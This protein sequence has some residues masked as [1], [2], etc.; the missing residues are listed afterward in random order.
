M[1]R[2]TLL[3]Q[4]WHVVVDSSRRAKIPARKVLTGLERAVVVA[5]G[6]VD[7]RFR[8]EAW[9]GPRD[10]VI[11]ADGGLTL[12]RLLGLRVDV[13]VGDLDSAPPELLSELDPEVELITFPREKDQTDTELALDLAAGRGA[14]EII[15]VGGAGGRLD[16]TWS[17]VTLLPRFVEQG[18]RVTLVDGQNVA[19]AT[20]SRALLQ[21]TPG[22]LVSL[23]PLSPEVS[24]ITTTGLKYG[25]Q[26]GRLAWGSSLGV[27]NEL[28]GERAEIS[29]EAGWLLVVLTSD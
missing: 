17:N 24:G 14:R 15:V 7:A 27:S 22:Q 9:V 4:E 25:L 16:H 3:S 12:A 26:R 8:P 11:C 23:L 21:G 18:L 5:N 2:R 13:V 10:L 29:V 19:F 28:L 1:R 20:R 6:R